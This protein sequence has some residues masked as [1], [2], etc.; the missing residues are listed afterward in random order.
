MFKTEQIILPM[1]IFLPFAGSIIIGFFRSTARNNEAFFAGAVALFGL[2]LTVMLYPSIS[3]GKIV[4]LSLPWLPQWGLNFTLRADGLAWLF[5]LL[6]TGIGFLIMIYAR[7]YMNPADPVPR[8][9]AFLLAF[10]GA[11]TGIVLSGNLILLAIFWELTSIFSFLLIGYWHHNAGARDAAKMSL[12]VTGMGGFALLAGVI[13]IGAAAGSFNLS[14]VL[15]SGDAIRRSP[16]YAPA[17]ICILLAAFTKSAQFPFHFWLPNAMSAP[18][19]ASA[20]LHSAT[21]VKAGVFLLVRLYPVMAGTNLWFWLVCC[22]GVMTMLIGAY[23]AMFK[24]DLKGLLAYSTISHLGIITT[25]LSFS[26]PLACVAAIFHIVNHA[27]FK[28]SLFMAAGIIDHEAGTRDLRKLSGLY[29]FM[30]WTGTLAIIAAAAMAGAPLLNGFLS[31]EM[32]FAEATETFRDNWLDKAMPYIV[33]AAG[34]LSVTYSVRF[35]YSSFFGPKP[36]D[37]PKTPHEP[38]HFMRLP[39]ELLVTLCLLVG[40][41][42]NFSIAPLLHNAAES[43]LGNHLPQYSLALWHGFNAPLIMSLIALAG[44]ILLYIILR[45]FMRGYGG[46]PPLIGLISGKRI[47]E[48]LLRNIGRRGARAAREFFSARD[49]RWQIRW[50]L[51]CAFTAVFAIMLQSGLWLWSGGLPSLPAGAYFIMLWACGAVC[52]IFAAS[53]AKFHR[54]SSLIM[55]GGAG[56]I[57][58]A[59]FVLLSA[60]DLALTQLSVEII[61]AVL[62]LL[63]LRWLP[64]P[65][66]NAAPET[67]GRFRARLRHG[68]DFALA[69]T[70]GGGM[71]WLSY[72]VM[73][74]P[75]DAGIADYFLANAYSHGGG[76]NA[77]NVILVDF[78]GFDTMGEITVLGMVA[79]S[80]YAL[81]RRF[82]PAPESVAA[83]RQQQMQ[84]K[85]AAKRY[86]ENS[87]EKSESGKEAES[88]LRDYMAIPAP[89]MHWLFP[90]IIAFSLY[91][92][93]RGH[94]SPGGGFVAGIVL[95]IGFILQYMASGARWVESHLVIMPLRW[96]GIGLL[97]A[98]CAGLGAW[99]FGYPFLTTF[100]TYAQIPLIGK[101]PIASALLFDMGVFCL[102]VGA[103]ILMLIALAHQ[104]L[105]HYR[106]IHRHLPPEPEH[107]QKTSEETAA[108]AEMHNQKRGAK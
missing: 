57:C 51:L 100:F 105:R 19:P 81:L 6:I 43:V 23:C 84:A 73:T 24:Q 31:K 11:M 86:A 47:F 65:P 71:A 4:E 59:C 29:R 49:L 89:V 92:F 63:G 34:L 8:F 14:A 103:T 96:M 42:P 106:I 50:A 10:M 13:L 101:T 26:A 20:Y 78:R 58:C 83:P 28:A 88:I 7:Y 15:A 35:I 33:T 99:V 93:F 87:D 102:V 60:P 18:T 56:L 75:Q 37:L 2:L 3:G 97:A 66:E 1:L 95:S 107:T 68:M 25:L 9:F 52:A 77:V 39:I 40:I 16:L 94:D 72:C 48:F 22:A 98:A 82:R 85:F 79:L 17:L 55:L 62:L 64:M 104:S 61:T 27:T 46:K 80:V 36:Q 21:M 108:P 67:A 44:G 74:R 38:P 76:T 5:L 41:A 30:P 70:G 45:R 54:L 69:L 90:F 12:V 32:F 53:R 91:L